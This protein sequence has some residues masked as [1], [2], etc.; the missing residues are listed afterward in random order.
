MAYLFNTIGLI[1]KYGDPS[2]EPMITLIG[3][4]L[5]RAGLRV[6]LDEATA[7][8]IPPRGLEVANRRTLGRLS[9]LA[10]V[11][12][13]DGTLLA[14]ARALVDFQV[15]IV[16]VNLGRLGFLAD[17]SPD[18]IPRGLDEILRGRFREEERSLLHAEVRRGNAVVSQADAL[19]DVVVHKRDVARMVELETFLDGRLLN[20]YR[21]DG[22]IISTPTG[23]TAY[24]LS[25]GGPLLH[26]LL[27]A[28]VLVP[29]CPHTLT[30]RPIV[31]AADAEIEI[32][33]AGHKATHA[34]VTCDGQ[35]SLALETGDRI[36]IR[37]KRRKLRLLH[38]N[39][40]D[41]F[42]LL[43]AKLRWGVSPEGTDS[44]R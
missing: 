38:P 33:V 16:G 27:E 15:P 8:L 36:V 13:G 5:R 31:V 12:G 19:N 14:A 43:R 11:V 30:H 44:N 35:I 29:I 18:E 32:V 1:G 9:E 7:E 24:A 28:V 20:T 22:L 41:Y 17:V 25:G 6:L 26:P 39:D 10:I 34:Q 37:K 23:S 21:A 2:V 42:E 40:H 4:F 3:D